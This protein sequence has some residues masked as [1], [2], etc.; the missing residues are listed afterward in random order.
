MKQFDKAEAWR[1]EIVVSGQETA[2]TESVR[3]GAELPTGLG[4]PAK[5]QKYSDAEPLLR[6]ALVIIRQKKDP[7]A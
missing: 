3:Y 7:D 6:E 1:P 4:K 2:G 5:Q